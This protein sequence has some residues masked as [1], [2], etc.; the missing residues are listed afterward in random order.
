MVDFLVPTMTKLRQPQ[1]GLR[2]VDLRK[3][4][5][6]IDQVAFESIATPYLLSDQFG[7]DVTG[8]HV[9]GANGHDFLSVTLRQ[10]PDQHCD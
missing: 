2:A 6:G 10:L 3:A 1:E 7:D 9:D 5:N 4:K 8:V